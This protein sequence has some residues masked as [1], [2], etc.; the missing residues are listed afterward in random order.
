MLGFLLLSL[1]LLG[2]AYTL[3][4]VTVRNIVGAVW[5]LTLSVFQAGALAILCSAY[6]RTTARAFTA[7][8][9]LCL[10]LGLGPGLTWFVGSCLSTTIED[11]LKSVAEGPNIAYTPV[12]VLPFCGFAMWI[13]GPG[14]FKSAS[15]VGPLAVQSAIF[16]ISIGVCLELARGYLVSRAFLPPGSSLLG[17]FQSLD[18]FFDRLKS[19]RHTEDV[20]KVAKSV[21]PDEEPV[22]WRETHKRALGQMRYLI[23]IALVIEVLLV[24][25][26]VLLLYQASHVAFDLMRFLF[27][28]MWGISVLI[29]VVHAVGLIATEKSHQT[30]DVLCTTP[31]T[32]R[33]IVLQK[34]R[35]VS[36]L[37][38]VLFVP[39]ATLFG[40]YCVLRLGRNPYFGPFGREFDVSLYLVGSVAAVVVYLPLAAWLS[41]AVGMRTR[42]QGRATITAIGGIA[43]WCIAP[44]L[45]ITAPVHSLFGR[46]DLVVGSALLSPFTVPFFLQVDDQFRQLPDAPWLALIV[47]FAI[48]AGM[49]ALIRHFCLR[50][51]DRWLGRLT[52]TADPWQLAAEEQ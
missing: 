24:F 52:A 35:G 33:D 41:L 12:V 38:A 27:A 47:N 51:A 28:V 23:R 39:F 18:R 49:V 34:F 48:Y 20:S 45:L 26:C 6:F 31:L 15:H 4:G 21:L 37:I 22:A 16:L 11:V 3:G 19:K 44:L 10:I 5:M 32:G 43:A 8:Y 50:N 29:V 25:F 2:F 30:L 42:T 40:F 1:P 46:T 13:D 14:P 9:V 7:S 36:R 17:W